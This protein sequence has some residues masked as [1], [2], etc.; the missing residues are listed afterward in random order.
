VSS[1]ALR[2]WKTLGLKSLDEIA[3]AHVAVG[4]SAR[5]RRY[6]TQQINN[7][8]TV[9]LSSQF[10][11][12]CRDLHSEASG[13]IATLGPA[14]LR[15]IVYARLTEGRKLDSGNPNPGNIGSDFGRL[16]MAFW[17]ELVA[18]NTE[19]SKRQRALDHLNVWRNAIAHQDFSRSDLQ[20]RSGV[21]LQEVRR[22]RRVCES[23]AI[24]ID[25]VVT[26]HLSDLS[27]M[28]PW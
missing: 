26:A 2:S 7:A 11:K 8:Y 19:N 1:N 6:A 21:V 24:D 5:G 17:D 22:W 10:Q 3:A 23:L 20:G 9:L 4:G 28:S 25:G 15:G 14:R 13:F 18:A 27:G 16:G 12:F